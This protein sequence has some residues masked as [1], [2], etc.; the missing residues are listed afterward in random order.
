LRKL[1]AP[2]AVA[3]LASGATAATAGAQTVTKFSVVAL[4]KHG[5]RIT[6]GFEIR[7]KLVEPGDRDD[8]VGTFEATFK[9]RNHT[10]FVAFFPDGKLKAN[11]NDENRKL[12]IVG[13]TRRWNGASGK[14]VHHSL[15][16]N[17]EFL[18]FT[19]VQ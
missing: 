10:R 1:I 17:A 13:G 19:V 6:G 16:E 2:V 5:H 14:L 11:G 3:A 8:V 12:P 4:V 15:G 18:T 7:G 9:R